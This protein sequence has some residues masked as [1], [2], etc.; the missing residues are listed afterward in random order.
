MVAA[1]KQDAL[2]VDDPSYNIK[3]LIQPG[4]ITRW[5]HPF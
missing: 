3:S 5:L 2:S 4:K 1:L